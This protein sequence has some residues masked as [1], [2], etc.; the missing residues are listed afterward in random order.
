MSLPPTTPQPVQGKAWMGGLRKTASSTAG[1][2]A[3]HPTPCTLHPTPYTL[4]PTPYVLH[5]STYTLHPTPYT[6]HPAPYTLQPTQRTQHP[7]PNTQHPAPHT[8]HST[9]YTLHPTHSLERASPALNKIVSVPLLDCS[10][11]ARAEFF[12]PPSRGTEQLSSLT[13]AAS[14]LVAESSKKMRGGAPRPQQGGPSRR[15]NL[16]TRTAPQVIS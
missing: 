8:Q 2:E 13:M 7:T 10:E 12:P 11:I 1:D 9:P 4:R 16:R 5:P 6:L 15:E 14:R 3:L